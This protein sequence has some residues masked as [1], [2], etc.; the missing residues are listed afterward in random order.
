MN[1][2]TK[3]TQ[4]RHPSD[5]RSSK[6][7]KSHAEHRQHADS[8][9]NRTT[10][11]N[12][13]PKPMMSATISNAGSNASVHNSASANTLPHPPNNTVGQGVPRPISATSKVKKNKLNTTSQL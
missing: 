11:K 2:E 4:W 8:N 10:H 7:S 3:S 5:P 12:H 13:T 6:G 1:H 9:H